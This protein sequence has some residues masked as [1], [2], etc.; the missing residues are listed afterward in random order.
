[1]DMM[2][3]AVIEKPPLSSPSSVLA[4]T[5]KLIQFPKSERLLQTTLEQTRQ[6][7]ALMVKTHF[8]DANLSPSAQFNLLIT[9]YTKNSQPQ[10]ALDIYAYLRRMD[11]EV[12]NFMVP[13]VLKA[14]SFVSMIQLGKEIHGFSVKSGFTKD[15]FVS[16]AMVKMYGECDSV[17]SAR[18][19]FDNMTER[20]DVSW[21]TM[22]RC[23][24]RNKLHREALE[25]IRKMQILQIRPSEV[26]MIIM[27]TLFADLIVTLFADR[28]DCWI[29]S[30]Q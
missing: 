6:I 1:M 29:Y 17:V 13:A 20:D 22:L 10:S 23:Y 30:L 14:C 7:H 15:V 27:V 25:T 24:V 2:K 28:Y 12:D 11:H 16:N 18:L 21:S 9:S 8:T 4:S 19:L 5:I 3:V 26:A